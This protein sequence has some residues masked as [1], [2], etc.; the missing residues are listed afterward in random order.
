MQGG[1]RERD[2]LSMYVEALVQ[3]HKSQENDRNPID[4][5]KTKQLDAAVCTREERVERAAVAGFDPG[6]VN[7]YHWRFC[8]EKQKCQLIR[9]SGSGK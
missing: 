1:T 6:L 4:G 2:I 9:W 7:L 5:S 3:F 8:R